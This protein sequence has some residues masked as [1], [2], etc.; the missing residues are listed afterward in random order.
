M[1][2]TNATKNRYPPPADERRRV[3]FRYG[4]PSDWARQV[5]PRVPWRIEHQPVSSGGAPLENNFVGQ[6]RRKTGDRSGRHH[7]WVDSK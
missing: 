7:F 3:P 5:P 6:Y 1:K 4:P 2:V